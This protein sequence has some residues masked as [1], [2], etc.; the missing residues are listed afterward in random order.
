MAADSELVRRLARSS[1]L[2]RS[3]VTQFLELD[4]VTLPDQ[5]VRPAVVRR[6]RRVRRMRRDLGLSLDAV[7]IIM[8]LLDRIEMLEGT[9]AHG[10]T[11]RILDQPPL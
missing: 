9:Q 3:E 10:V 2:S 6:L 1:G 11:A 5:T 7:V 8:R 4:L